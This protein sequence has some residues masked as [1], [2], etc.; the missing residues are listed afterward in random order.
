LPRGQQVTSVGA[1]TPSERS[2]KRRPRGSLSADQILSEA[3]RLA[4]EVGLDELSMSRLAVRLDVPVTSMYW[5]FRSKDELLHALTSAAVKTIDEEMPELSGLDWETHLERY[6]RSYRDILRQRPILAELTI[7][8]VLSIAHSPGASQ[9]H[10]IRMNRQLTV[11][12]EAGFTAEQ[13]MRGYA[14]LAGFT[15]GCIQAELSFAAAVG[16]DDPTDLRAVQL[17]WATLPTLQAVAPYWTPALATDED[18]DF[19]VRAILV[20]LRFLLDQKP[21]GRKKGA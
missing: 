2:G 20:G 8:R 14:A 1:V 15:R 17:E 11:M 21:R 12:V 18:F 16:P 19:G 10:A 5:Y 7:L 13:A 4:E 3:F 6:W 9:R